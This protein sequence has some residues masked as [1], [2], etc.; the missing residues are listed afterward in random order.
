M[1]ILCDCGSEYSRDPQYDGYGIFLCYT[2]PACHD[3][4]MQRYRRDIYRRY[5]TDEAIE[6]DE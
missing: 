5:Q 6:P 2:C 1:L 3:E 4:K